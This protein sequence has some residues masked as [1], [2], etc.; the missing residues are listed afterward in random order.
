[1]LDE[2]EKK[3]TIM[4]NI[5]RQEDILNLSKRSKSRG[6]SVG[7]D[8]EGHGNSWARLKN[9][10]PANTSKSPVRRPM[11]ANVNRPATSKER[12]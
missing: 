11:T 1:M 2:E 6:T 4:K 9:V 3:A 8:E 10:N 7:K 5:Q 12:R